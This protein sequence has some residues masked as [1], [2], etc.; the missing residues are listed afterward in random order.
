M[1]TRIGVFGGA[2]DPPHA[3][4]EAL[5]QAASVQ[6]DLQRLLIIPTGQAW[7]K[8]RPLTAATHR[9]AMCRLAFAENARIEIDARETR[10]AGA[11]YTAETLAQLREENPQSEFFLIIGTDQAIFFRHWKNAAGIL[12]MCRILIAQRGDEIFPVDGL[13]PG[14]ETA[15]GRVRNLR[16]EPISISSTDIRRR[17]AAGTDIGEYVKPTV[18]AYIRQHRLYLS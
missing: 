7:H 4:H 10:R 18:A 2:F 8:A 5:A 9:L 11:S 17:V 6:A 15:P 14:T 3:A 12:S 1:T 16:F 13:L